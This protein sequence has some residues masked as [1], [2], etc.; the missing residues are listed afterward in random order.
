M[1]LGLVVAAFLLGLGSGLGIGVQI[2]QAI[3]SHLPSVDTQRRCREYEKIS[4][5]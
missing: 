2:G 4:D 3:E 5:S 1:M